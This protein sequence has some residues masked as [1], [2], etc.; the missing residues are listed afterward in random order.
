M[1]GR[2]VLIDTCHA[3]LEDREIS[4]DRVRI[5]AAGDVRAVDAVNRDH[6]AD[7]PHFIDT[8][9]RPPSAA[10]S[11]P[12]AILEIEHLAPWAKVEPRQECWRAEPYAST[13]HSRLWRNRPAQDPRSEPRRAGPSA[14]PC[15]LFVQMRTARIE[16]DRQP[17]KVVRPTRS[18][19]L[20]WLED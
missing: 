19:H 6:A 12:H 14:R 9:A 7:L 2:A 3:P 18:T 10:A 4:V 5:R 20:P 11:T 8:T 1:V 16:P 13:R 17:D 15:S